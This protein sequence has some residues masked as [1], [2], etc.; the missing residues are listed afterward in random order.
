MIEDL[1]VVDDHEAA[2]GAVHGLLT[3]RHIDDTQTPVTEPDARSEV[4]SRCVRPAMRDRVPHSL[5]Q[6]AIRDD[7]RVNRQDAADTAHEDRFPPEQLAA[8]RL[9]NA[10]LL[11]APTGIGQNAHFA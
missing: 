8:S 3:M 1:A 2:I 9:I 10:K 5:H 7:A 11:P 4:Q 6:A